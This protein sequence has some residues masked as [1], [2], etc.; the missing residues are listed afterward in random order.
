MKKLKLF[1]TIVFVIAF[2]NFGISQTFHAIIFADTKAPDIGKSVEKDLEHIKAE[3]G[4]ISYYLNID[5][6]L[7]EKHG[8]NANKETLL[9][10]LD[11]L[12]CKPEDIVFFYYS[13]HGAR[14]VEDKS[15]FPQITFKSRDDQSYPL[16][17]VDKK[18]ASKK[19]KFRLVM[20]DLCNTKSAYINSKYDT[21]N[22][23]SYVNAKG[24][25]AAL[26]YQNLFENVTGGVIV[27]SSK[28]GEPSQAIAEGGVF[29]LCFLYELQELY[30]DVAN[31][32]WKTLLERTQNTTL[33]VTTEINKEKRG[34]TP[35]FEINLIGENFATT[36]SS[37]GVQSTNDPLI[38][39][40]IQMAD[41]GNDY[42][43][44]INL[45]KPALQYFSS[46]AIVETYSRNGNVRLTREKASDFLERV[47][48][49]HNL[50]NFVRFNTELD[51]NG[52][53]KYLKLHEFYKQ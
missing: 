33:M 6:N 22:G 45:T 28:A 15:P 2:S 46:S 47:S 16:D 17:L 35:I 39:T 49:A 34:H 19:P 10:V 50:V 43:T 31:A 7:V 27:S 21:G 23:K 12:Q 14:A 11:D 38:N 53:I 25:N 5:V 42:A 1:L 51:E 24:G 20:G 30:N 36:P 3:I 37:V 18:I 48:T 4:N 52:K 32:N 13:G 29:T 26:V 40:L 9:K 44:R 8:I 41:N